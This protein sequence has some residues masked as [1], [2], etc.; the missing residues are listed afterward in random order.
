[1]DNIDIL[2][3]TLADQGEGELKFQYT[4]QDIEK[5]RNTLPC[6]TCRYAKLVTLDLNVECTHKMRS[7]KAA[8]VCQDY[9]KKTEY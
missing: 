8:I 7:L 2:V 9:A 4:P 6:L 1:L 3:L 5:L